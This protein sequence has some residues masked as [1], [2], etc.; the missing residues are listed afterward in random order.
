MMSYGPV[1]VCREKG[2]KRDSL[3]NK[4]TRFAPFSVTTKSSRCLGEW[5]AVFGPD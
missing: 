3:C 4:G 1:F 2:V 5:S